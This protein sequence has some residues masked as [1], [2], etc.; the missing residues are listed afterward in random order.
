MDA[1]NR[2]S[3]VCRCT[4]DAEAHRISPIVVVSIETDR[5]ALYNFGPLAQ[6]GERFAGSEEV[7]GSS[8]LRS[9]TYEVKTAAMP[10]LFLFEG[11]RYIWDQVKILI[12]LLF[13]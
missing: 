5:F 2:G 7:G 11:Y 4:S 13:G 1:S 3:R 12:I 6:L 8:P 10:F 9:I